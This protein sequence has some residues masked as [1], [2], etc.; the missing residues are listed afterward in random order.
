[1]KNFIHLLPLALGLIL[2]GTGC[3][4]T[5]EVGPPPASQ[6]DVGYLREEIRRMNARLDATDTEMGRLQSDLMASRSSQPDTASASQVQSVKAQVDDLQRQ[7]RAVDAAR[8]KDNKQIY[9]DLTKKISKLLKSSS[10]SSS[11]SRSSSR[12]SGSQSGIEHEVKPGQTLSQIASAYGVTTK[13]LVEE[14]GLK[15][16]NAI[17]AGQK[18]FI[19][20]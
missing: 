5:Q 4:T 12:R 11:H 15:N 16:A 13:V 2:A 17:Y 6:A 20:D 3:V 1:M 8:A 10:S 9:D 18:L 14:N 19:P 7:I